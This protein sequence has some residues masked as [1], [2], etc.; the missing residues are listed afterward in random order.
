ML[1]AGAFS[2]EFCYAVEASYGIPAML[3]AGLSEKYASTM[4]AVGPVLGLLFQ[5]YLGAASDRCRSSW[6]RRRPFILGLAVSA[7][8]SIGFFPYG[9]ALSALLHL[10]GGAAQL[11]VMLFTAA[12]F[13]L[14]DFSLDAFQ[15]PV[16]A[17]LLDSVPVDASERANYLFTTMLG[18]GA[19]FGFLVSAIPYEKLGI[20]SVGD[21]DTQVKII[22]GLCLVVMVSSVA[23]TL[24]S[25]TEKSSSSTGSEKVGRQFSMPS[26]SMMESEEEEEEEDHVGTKASVAVVL[27]SKKAYSPYSTERLTTEHFPGNRPLQLQAGN[28]ETRAKSPQRITTPRTSSAVLTNRALTSNVPALRRNCRCM[29]ELTQSLHGTFLFAKYMSR[30]F[31]SLW[32][33]MVFSQVAFLSQY[34]FFTNFVGEVIYSGSPVS[35]DVNIRELYTKGVRTGCWLLMVSC[36]ITF[37]FSLTSKWITKYI[38]VRLLFIGGHIVFWVMILAVMVRPSLFTALCLSAASGL[39]YANLLSVPYS[40][41]SHYHVSHPFSSN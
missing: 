1:T 32:L 33:M 21:L 35:D 3:K 37:L 8:I 18:L 34:L 4:W 22:F 30:E 24:N 27:R 9:R 6:G 5:S 40:L 31:L 13:V 19:T 16:R 29:V 36:V 25:V 20:V 2:L 15:S 7:C 28:K 41:I 12:T 14:M 17:Y 11:C 23:L 10:E 38:S 26:F 39:Y